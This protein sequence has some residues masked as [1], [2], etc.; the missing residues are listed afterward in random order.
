MGIFPPGGH[1]RNSQRR[2]KRTESSPSGSSTTTIRGAIRHRHALRCSAPDR[3]FHPTGSR[4]GR[5][6]IAR[7]PPPPTISR[8]SATWTSWP[9][10]SM[11]PLEFRLKN[12]S[13]ERLRAVFTPRRT[14][15]DG[16]AQRSVRIAA[17]GLPVGQ[18]KAVT[19]RLALRF[20]SILRPET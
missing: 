13:D 18:K 7:L 10:R 4:C 11:D 2:R 17:P 20:R 5:G 15:S 12:L 16:A 19:S 1:D 6:P 8:A 3:S 9:S 14:A